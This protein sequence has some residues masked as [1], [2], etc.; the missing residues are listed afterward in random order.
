MVQ[1]STAD[2][3]GVISSGEGADRGAAGARGSTRMRKA[4][5]TSFRCQLSR[6]GQLHSAVILLLCHASRLHHRCVGRL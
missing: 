6:Y 3:G 4:L 5:A 1:G 2:V